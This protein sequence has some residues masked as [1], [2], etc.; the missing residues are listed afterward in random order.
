MAAGISR[1]PVSLP[2][3]SPVNELSSDETALDTVG[4]EGSGTTR[5]CL[6]SL[7][8]FSCLLRTGSLCVAQAG[9]ECMIP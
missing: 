1:G 4:R 7:L 5:G 6:L 2:H 8:V 3:T 9:L